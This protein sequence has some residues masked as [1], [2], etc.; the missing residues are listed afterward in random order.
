MTPLAW[1]VVLLAGSCLCAF[2]AGAVCGFGS[3][4]DHK[5]KEPGVTPAPMSHFPTKQ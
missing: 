4:C 1:A 2:F 3:D 5:R